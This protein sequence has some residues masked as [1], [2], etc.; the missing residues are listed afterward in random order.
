MS[1]L[2]NEKKVTSFTQVATTY[3]LLGLNPKL[4]IFAL[5]PLPVATGFI[6]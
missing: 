2:A 1:P 6:A 5:V 4:K 3:V